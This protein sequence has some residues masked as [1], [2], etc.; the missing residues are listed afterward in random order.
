MK[1][2]TLIV[3]L[4]IPF[5]IGLISFVSVVLLNITVASDIS[6]IVWKYNDGTEGFKLNKEV[7]YKLEAEPVFDENLI[8]ATGNDLMRYVSD[9]E[10]VVQIEKGDDG[11][12]Y[13]VTLKEGN[14]TIV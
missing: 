1:K 3:L 12:Y 14:A 5:I 7:P 11:A 13:L 6:G 4:I 8:L 9:G 2:K 10:D